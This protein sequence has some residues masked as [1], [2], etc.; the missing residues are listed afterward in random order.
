MMELKP[1]NPKGNQPWIFIGRIDAAAEAP[2]LWPPDIRA[3]SLEKPLMLGKIE[4]RRRRGW[5]WD[6]MIGWHHRFNGHE[7]EQA[8]GDGKGQ[9]SPGVLPLMEVLKSWTWLSDKTTTKMMDLDEPVFL[10]CESAGVG[11]PRSGSNRGSHV[12]KA[13]LI[14][15]GLS[16]KIRL[17]NYVTLIQKPRGVKQAFIS[18]LHICQSPGAELV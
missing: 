7:C 9:A 16:R 13:F 12:L 17:W 6:E 15:L 11:L 14:K 4:G 5:G 10:C 3:D 8:L 2:I 1:V 18:G